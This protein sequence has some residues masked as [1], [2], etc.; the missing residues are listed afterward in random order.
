MPS[1]TEWTPNEYTRTQ[2]ETQRV[3]TSLSDILAATRERVDGL[4]P[5]RKALER[6]AAQVPDPPSFA[7]ALSRADVAII[8][9]V[10]RRSPSAGVISDIPSAG[11]HAAAYQAGGAAAVSV[12]TDQEHFGGALED[13]RA[14]SQAVRVPV[15][16][17]DFILDE[18]QLYEARGMGAAAVLLIVRALDREQLRHLAAS[19]RALGLGSLVEVHDRSELER[20]LSVRPDAVGINARD[21]DTFA[22]DVNRLESVLAEVPAAVPAVAESGLSTRADVER[23]AHWGADAALVGTALA[24]SADPAAAVRALVGVRRVGRT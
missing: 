6:A 9:E 4:K 13:L 2:P 7:A 17:K 1:V 8:A 19:A 5:R 20:A 12:L 3:T 11:A 14:V 18:V 23:V 24:K 16:R 10:K 21:L 22:V 15:L